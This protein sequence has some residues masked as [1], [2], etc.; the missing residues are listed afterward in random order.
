[1][2][3]CD[4]HLSCIIYLLSTSLATDFASNFKANNIVSPS[5]ASR[6]NS[7]ELRPASWPKKLLW[8]TTTDNMR[9]VSAKCISNFNHA[10]NLY[11]N[12][13]GSRMPDST[14]S[15]KRN[16]LQAKRTARLCK[17]QDSSIYLLNPDPNP[18]PCRQPDI[19]FG[20]F[21]WSLKTFMFG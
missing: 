1:M 20:Q 10:N 16:S 3:K 4:K 15:T 8:T 6:M 12:L 18:K 9:S 13:G 17:I 7:I 2:Q 19:T 21:K 11:R 14:R 5:W